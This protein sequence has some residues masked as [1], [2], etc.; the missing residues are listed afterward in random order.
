M[1]N[2]EIKPNDPCPCGRKRPN[3]LPMKYRKCCMYKKSREQAVY[4]PINSRDAV[5]SITIDSNSRKVL[6]HSPT[7]ETKEPDMVFSMTHYK[8]D[9]YDRNV[10]PMILPDGT[11]SGHDGPFKNIKPLSMLEGAVLG[12]E[13]PFNLIDYLDSF[14]LVFCVDTSTDKISGED[15]SVGVSIR[16]FVK[17]I[18]K[19]GK[20]YYSIPKTEA[21][22]KRL[23]PSGAEEYQINSISVGNLNIPISKPRVLCFKGIPCG[24]A[25]KYIWYQLLKNVLEANND[26][27]IKIALITDHRDNWGDIKLGKMPVYGDFYLPK[28]VSF[29][30][31]SDAANENILNTAIRECDKNGKQIIEKL[32]NGDCVVIGQYN[33]TIDK[34]PRAQE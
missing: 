17:K 34:I 4:F 22:Q 29:I 21:F 32:K 6:L 13:G 24:A 8:K 3:G 1:R 2:I 18:R 16:M 33:I 28:N 20:I 30:Y 14:D 12:H 7:G 15:V 26:K 31:A 25:E 23:G 5:S 9:N 10:K 27:D 11:S 19:D